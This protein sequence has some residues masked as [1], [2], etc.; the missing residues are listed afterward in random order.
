MRTAS[1]RQEYRFRRLAISA[2]A[3]VMAASAAAEAVTSGFSHKATT[4]WPSQVLV[5]SFTPGMIAAFC[6]NSRGQG[7]DPTAPS[8]TCVFTLRRRRKLASAYLEVRGRPPSIAAS[9]ACSTS[10]TD[11]LRNLAS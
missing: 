11:S 4:T 3:A 2:T 9:A 5:V 7:L 10:I 6:P 8:Q 1:R